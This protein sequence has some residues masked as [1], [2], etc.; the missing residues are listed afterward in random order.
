M[1]TL[2]YIAAMGLLTL[3]GIVSSRWIH[4][5]TTA[6]ISRGVPVNM[7]AKVWSLI[8][9]FGIVSGMLSGL[10]FIWLAKPRPVFHAVV[11]SAGVLFVSLS[12]AIVTSR[13][14]DSG[15]VR[16]GTMN[17]LLYVIVSIS[18]YILALLLTVVVWRRVT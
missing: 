13:L 6:V 2:A 3:D 16:H 11:Y 14:F 10:C 4:Q 15:I 5:I 17:D 1:T 7:G 12:L 18:P 8:V 9:C